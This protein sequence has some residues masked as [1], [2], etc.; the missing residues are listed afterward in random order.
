MCDT[1]WVPGA[2]RSLFAKSS[3]RPVGEAQ[4]VEPAAARPAGGT[5]RTQYLELDDPGAIELLGSRPTWLRGLEHGVNRHRVAIGNERVWTLDDPSGAPDALI[6]MDLVR[7]GLERA[8]TAREGVEVIGGLLERHGQGGPAE[9][10][11][12]EPYWSSFLVADPGAAWVL[13][14][15][16][17]R[18]AAR[19]VDP[20]RGAAISNRLGIGDDWELGSDPPS[21]GQ[22]F[23]D[24][25]DQSWAPIADVRLACTLPAVADPSVTGPADL[26]GL[27]RH[28]GER[29]W[30]RPGDDPGDVSP[31][32]PERLGPA[33]E[34]VTVC[35]HVRG[36]QVTAASM[37]CELPEDPTEPV[38]AWAALASPCSSLYLPIFPETDGGVPP[39]L[40]EAGTWARFDELRT[41]SEADPEALAVTRAVLGPLE[42]ELWAEADEV[43]ADP[44][45]H[46]AL[47][48]RSWARVDA[49]LTALGV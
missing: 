17:D 14:T 39:A 22:R 30:G 45:G 42:A 21:G 26:V 23:D 32:P 44:A 8:R 41:R 2:G 29:P 5:L 3:D 19:P 28:H 1:V 34:G 49:A 7:L 6:G 24:R 38:R 15:S 11:D 48:A 12:G 20:G 47:V 35:M 37:V 36:L 16:G 33:G 43:A 18:W 25:R 27:L 31:L 9:A 40:A 10:P 13:E 46:A 4:V